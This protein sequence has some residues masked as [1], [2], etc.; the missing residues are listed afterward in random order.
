MN[1]EKVIL[2]DEAIED[3]KVGSAVCFTI[4]K[5]KVLEIIL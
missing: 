1:S 3:L 5:D 4:A 2:L